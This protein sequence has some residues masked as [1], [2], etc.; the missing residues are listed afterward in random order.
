MIQI[1][2]VMQYYKLHDSHSSILAGQ[3]QTRKL[4][5][6]IYFHSNSDKITSRHWKLQLPFPNIYVI[7][8][9]IQVTDDTFVLRFITLHFKYEFAMAFLIWFITFVTIVLTYCYNDR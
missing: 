3:R 1:T 8:V 2:L 9:D 4:L 6:L 7:S 5:S